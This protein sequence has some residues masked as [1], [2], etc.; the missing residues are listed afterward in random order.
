MIKS[1]IQQWKLFIL[2]CVITVIVILIAA[3][4]DNLT[5]LLRYDALT[6]SENYQYWRLF[7]AHFTHLGW[8]HL[9]LN[10]A[11]LMMIFIFFAACLSTRYW[12]I[13]FLI[14]SICISIL[15]YFFNPEIRWYVGLSGVL[16]ALFILGGIAD[17][18]TRKWE[19]ISFT[20]I[21]LAKVIYEQF[22]GPLPGSEEAAG[23][24]VLVDAHFYGAMM[25]LILAL[26]LIRNQLKQ[27][28]Q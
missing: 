3:V 5:Q 11:G 25:G 7:T 27:T 12:I 15:I 2:P 9:W 19:G 16:H 28:K 20:A 26:P 1:L 6:I 22:T 21:V 8:S 17:I 10:V 18:R 23:G 24:P 14:A 13:S 4:G